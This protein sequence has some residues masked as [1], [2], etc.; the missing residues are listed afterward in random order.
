MLIIETLLIYGAD[1]NAADNY[2]NTALMYVV[3][4]IKLYNRLEVIKFLV[5]KGA[6][7]SGACLIAKERGFEDITKALKCESLD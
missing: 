1:V 5:E 4:S 3:R 7:I 6:D 2:N